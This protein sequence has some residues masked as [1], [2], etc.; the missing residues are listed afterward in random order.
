MTASFEDKFTIQELI[1]RYNHAIDC[2]NYD[3]WVDCFAEDGLC[4]APRPGVLSAAPNSR[5]SLNNSR[6]FELL[7][8]RW[9]TV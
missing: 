2:G 8:P 6:P 9:A 5:S 3:A 4:K 1:A 7:C